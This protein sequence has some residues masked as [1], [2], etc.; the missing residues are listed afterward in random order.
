MAERIFL[1]CEPC[2]KLPNCAFKMKTNFL[3]VPIEW[4]YTYN[5]SVM[6]IKKI[7]MV[8][9]EITGNILKIAKQLKVC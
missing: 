3:G 4:C 7:K 6:G 9:A 1:E 8:R 2:M 5:F